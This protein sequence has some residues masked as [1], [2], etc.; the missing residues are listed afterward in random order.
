MKEDDTIKVLKENGFLESSRKP[1]LFVKDMDDITV[2]ADLRS[3]K[4][5]F[6]GYKDGTSIS[7]PN[8]PSSIRRIKQTIEAHAKGQQRLI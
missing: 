5:R 2:F 3:G 8:L 4:L 6:Y 1:N 7:Y